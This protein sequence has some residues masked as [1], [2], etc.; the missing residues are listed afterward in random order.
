MVSSR[1]M[2]GNGNRGWAFLS[3]KN[4]AFVSGGQVCLRGRDKLTSPGYGASTSKDRGSS[5]VLAIRGERSEIHPAILEITSRR[6]HVP[7]AL[8]CHVLKGHGG[9][10]KEQKKTS[11]KRKRFIKN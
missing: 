7:L 9:Y 6:R 3:K 11:N 8:K 2:A 1:L 10:G 4:M 5:L